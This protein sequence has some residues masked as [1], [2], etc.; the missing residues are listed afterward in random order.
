MTDYKIGI[1]YHGVITADPEFFAHFCAVALAKNCRI[2]IISGG[3]KED[4]KIYLSEHQIPYSYMWSVVEFFGKR[5]KVQHFADGSF[6][7]DDH[8][9]NKAKAQFCLKTGIDFHIDDSIVYGQYFKSP[10]C[11]YDMRRKVCCMEGPETFK[12][13]FSQKP[14]KVLQDITDIIKKNKRDH[15]LK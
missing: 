9:W 3:Y 12:V 13:D 11:L 14:E 1:D 5:K 6:K 8:L 15:C 7:V 2:Y 4:I 10:F